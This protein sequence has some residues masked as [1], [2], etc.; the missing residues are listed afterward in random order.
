MFLM[1]VDFSDTNFAELKK[2]MEELVES[3]VSTIGNFKVV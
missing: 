2:Q 1:C 3:S